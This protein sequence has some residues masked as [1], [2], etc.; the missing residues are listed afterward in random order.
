MNNLICVCCLC[1]SGPNV[2]TFVIPV[3]IFPTHIRA[4]GHGISAALGKLGAV[5]GSSIMP[6]L[7]GSTGLSGV[8]ILSAALSIIGII[9]TYY[10]TDESQHVALTSEDD[11]LDLDLDNNNTLNNTN[12]L[13]DSVKIN[14]FNNYHQLS[15]NNNNQILI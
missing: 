6:E 15:K 12:D 1:V 13:N 11:D 4:T 8:F 5:L 3:E 2:S 9:F 7:L 10:M 14:N